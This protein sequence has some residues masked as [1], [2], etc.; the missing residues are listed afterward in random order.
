MKLGDY[1]KN[2]RQAEHLSQSDAGKRLG[3]NR[4]TISRY[5]RGV[6]YP[7]GYRARKELAEA[8]EISYET[9]YGEPE[10]LVVR[11]QLDVERR[12]IGQKIRDYRLIHGLNQVE[13]AARVSPDLHQSVVTDR[14]SVV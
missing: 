3:V 13:F 4:D 5:E 8:L 9:L 10:P 14:K 1:L 12:K 6:C 2:W 11:K 7:R